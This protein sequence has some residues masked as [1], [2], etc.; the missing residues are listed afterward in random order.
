MG[1]VGRRG[2]DLQWGSRRLSRGGSGPPLLVA[3]PPGLHP[4]PKA[5]PEPTRLA[6]LPG[7]FGDL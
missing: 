1:Q 2:V 5:G 6:T 3:D 7:S 4:D